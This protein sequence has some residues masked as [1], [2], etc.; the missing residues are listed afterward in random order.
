MKMKMK[1][2]KIVLVLFVMCLFGCDGTP[3]ANQ[4]SLAQPDHEYELDTWGTNSEVY[5]FTPRSST[6]HTCV[7]YILDNMKA[8]SMQCFLKTAK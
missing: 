3:D 2:K 4:F 6:K 5:E 1:M 8:T 7:V